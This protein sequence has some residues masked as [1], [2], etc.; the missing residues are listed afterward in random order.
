MWLKL[1]GGS[2]W[3]NM[4]RIVEV[5]FV[6]EDQANVYM[7]SEGEVSITVDGI[8]NVNVLR[9]FLRQQEYQL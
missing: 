3:L 8:P 9:E 6:S 7:G 1:S 5:E 2:L 4:E